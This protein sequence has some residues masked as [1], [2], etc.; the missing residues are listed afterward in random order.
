[1]S[2]SRPTERAGDR[3]RG[4]ASIEFA[5]VAPLLALTLLAGT[6]LALFMRGKMRMDQTV[7]EL[8]HVVTQYQDLYAGDFAALFD[9]AQVIAG[10]MPVTGTFGATIISGI[11]NTSGRQTVAWQQRTGAANFASRFGNAGAV[12][13]MPDSY[14]VPAGTALIAVEVFT[15][16]STWVFS[17]ALM[18]ESS[19]SSI[20]AFALFQPR[21][22]TLSQIRAGN[23]P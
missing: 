7:T 22:G 6:D 11:V 19:V 20:S 8:A 16:A 13:V 14:V 12:P 10:T 2:R 4:I 5:L 21:L 15:P 23:R 3:R 1:M 9:A 17:A 18:G